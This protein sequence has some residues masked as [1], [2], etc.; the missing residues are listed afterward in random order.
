MKKIERRRILVNSYMQCIA[1]IMVGQFGIIGRWRVDYNR[2]CEMRRARS[3]NLRGNRAGLMCA[4]PAWIEAPFIRRILQAGLIHNSIP[5][6]DNGRHRKV[7]ICA[8]LP[9]SLMSQDIRRIGAGGSAGLPA[10]G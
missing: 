4:R 10:D 5:D 3:G 7:P 9:S 1:R 2:I 8:A 6:Q